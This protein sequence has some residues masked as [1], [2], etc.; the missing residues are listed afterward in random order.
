[1]TQWE[2]LRKQ[3][4]SVQ[5]PPELADRVEAAMKTGGRRR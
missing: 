4:E 5:P 1:M 2:E 3:Y